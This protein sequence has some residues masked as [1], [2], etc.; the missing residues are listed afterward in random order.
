MTDVGP[1]GRRDAHVPTGDHGAVVRLAGAFHLLG[2]GSLLIFLDLRFGPV[3]VLPD[4]VGALV[5]AWGAAR[6]RSFHRGASAVMTFALTTGILWIFEFLPGGISFGSLLA[7]YVLHLA[8]VWLIGGIVIDLGRALGNPALTASASARR[9]AYM[10]AAGAAIL[11]MLAVFLAPGPIGSLLLLFV[12]V[13]NVV[14]AVLLIALMFKAAQ[15]VSNASEVPLTFGPVTA[16]PAATSHPVAAPAALSPV[17]PPTGVYRDSSLRLL[18]FVAGL[19]AFVSFASYIVDG[20]AWRRPDEA[21]NLAIP[22]ALAVLLVG[23]V[24]TK[25]SAM[26]RLTVAFSVGLF[27]IASVFLGDPFL[28]VAESLLLY[29]LPVWLGVAVL[30]TGR[31]RFDAARAVGATLILMAVWRPIYGSFPE[32]TEL[33][34]ATGVLRSYAVFTLYR[35]VSVKLLFEIL[36]GFVGLLLLTG[37]FPYVQKRPAWHNDVAAALASIQSRI[38]RNVWTDLGLGCT[39]LLLAFFGS[40]S[41]A[42]ILNQFRTLRTGADA[43]Q[44]WSNMTPLLVFLLSLAAGIGEELLFRGF[45]QTYFERLWRRA[46]PGDPIIALL[47]A[48]FV[49]AILFGIVHAGNLTVI[50]VLI[51]FSFGVLAGFVFRFWGMLAI[52]YAHTAIDVFAF[53]FEAGT[54]HFPG[55]FVFLTIFFFLNLAVGILTPV[56]LMFQWWERRG[57]KRARE[58]AA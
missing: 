51:P 17:S 44:I 1:P 24:R 31:Y 21:L 58:L 33:F 20:D 13:A 27:V 38:K 36:F 5:I 6:I 43:S 46:L 54:N 49:Q 56:F 32:L 22:C 39:A 10:A 41:L 52:M 18:L 23:V 57:A 50:G 3:D 28:Y 7:G 12:V 37:R 48:I 30:G 47:L 42:E 9:T 25:I 53:G 11:L 26:A 19:F 45:L 35:I 4:V 55:I 14:A 8:T 16:Q 29:F 34:R 40:Q 2:F 15:A